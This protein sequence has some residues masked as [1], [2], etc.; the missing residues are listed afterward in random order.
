MWKI[1]EF[2]RVNLQNLHFRW[3]QTCKIAL[4]FQKKESIEADALF[5]HS[6]FGM[7]YMVCLIYFLVLE[8]TTSR[9]IAVNSSMLMAPRSPSAR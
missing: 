9:N 3:W 5:L 4:L 1:A 8:S 2:C 7:L 6:I